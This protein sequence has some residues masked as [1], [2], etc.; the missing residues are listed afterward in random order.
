M[1]MKSFSSYC[2]SALASSALLP[3]ICTRHN[4]SSCSEIRW[5]TF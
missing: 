1:R 4:G 2:R 5:I 3:L